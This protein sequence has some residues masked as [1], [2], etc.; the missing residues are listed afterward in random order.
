MPGVKNVANSARKGNSCGVHQKWGLQVRSKLKYNT[1]MAGSKRMRV[2][3]SCSS[4]R[5]FCLNAN[6][7][8]HWI[9]CTFVEFEP[10]QIFTRI[11][12]S[13]PQV[14]QH[15]CAVTKL[16]KFL[17]NSHPWNVVDSCSHWSGV[18]MQELIVFS[19]ENASC[20]PPK[21]VHVLNC[22]NPPSQKK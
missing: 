1:C 6:S 10:A 4:Y 3:E 2:V 9:F 19:L 18:Y 17:S 11:G 21:D 12:V 8:V 20:F 14:I 16:R 22:Y 15:D 13:L 5:Y 7:H